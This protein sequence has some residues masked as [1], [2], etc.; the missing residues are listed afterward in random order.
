LKFFDLGFYRNAFG[1]FEN[2]TLIKDSETKDALCRI[3]GACATKYHYTAQSC[4]SIMHLVHKYDYVVTHMA[5]AVAGAEKKYADGTL[6]SSLIREVGRT[7]PKAYVKDTV[8][9]ENVGRFLVELADRL[10][11]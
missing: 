5:D 3:I 7:N 1:L 6:A 8:G 9:A 11:V 4:A 2:A 10:P